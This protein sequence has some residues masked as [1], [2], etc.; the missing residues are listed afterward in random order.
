[1]KPLLKKRRD[2][3]AFATHAPDRRQC[4]AAAQQQVPVAD[5]S[6]GADASSH[7]FASPGSGRNGSA[8]TTPVS[9]QPHASIRTRPSQPLRS[10]MQTPV[11]GSDERTKSR[12]PSTWSNNSIQQVYR[13]AS[14]PS[15]GPPKL[16][17][18]YIHKR[19]PADSHIQT[20]ACLQPFGFPLFRSGSQALP[21]LNNDACARRADA[22]GFGFACLRP[23]LGA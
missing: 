20:S 13:Q 18:W 7:R 23:N 21:A 14:A 15:A 9:D 12:E 4:P 2:E 1:V 17:P 5:S 6:T 19:L 16:P 3:P 10:A 22:S 11:C 8:V